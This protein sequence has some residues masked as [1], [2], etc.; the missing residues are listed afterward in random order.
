MPM[1]IQGNTNYFTEV[2]SDREQNLPPCFSDSTIRCHVSA[3]Q[4]LN[5]VGFS[6]SSSVL[7]EQQPW[8]L[9]SILSCNTIFLLSVIVV[10]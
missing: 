9:Q 5:L 8:I 6:A 7:H 2:I 10:Q 4:L 1:C 3:I